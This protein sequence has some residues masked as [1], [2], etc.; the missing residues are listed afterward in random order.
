M[1]AGISCGEFSEVGDALAFVIKID[2]TVEVFEH[3]G[4][5]FIKR[6]GGGF[7]VAGDQGANFVEY[8][9][10]AYGAASDGHRVD[11]GLFEALN[12]G[13]RFEHIA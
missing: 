5:D 1:S 4:A 12:D 8:P 10:V 3:D 9:G 11:A 6:G 13:F 7:G 2:D